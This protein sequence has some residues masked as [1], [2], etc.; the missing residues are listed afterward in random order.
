MTRN[1]GFEVSKG[2]LGQCW[3]VDCCDWLG[4]KEDDICGLD[5]NRISAREKMV[6]IYP[7]SIELVEMNDYFFNKTTSGH[8][9][10]RAEKVIYQI[11]QTMLQEK[12]KIFSAFNGV[13]LDI[14]KLSSG[15]KTALNI[16]YFPDKIVGIQECGDNALNV[17]YSYEQGNVYCE[18]PMISFQMSRV[19][20]VDQ[21]GKHI[22]D[23]YEVV[24]EW[25]SNVQ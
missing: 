9:D 15:C 8:I 1:T 12:Y 7:K 21:Y 25:W 5:E 2:S 17:I 11:D 19:A 3:L 10:E 18:Y 14:D 22:T 13:T 23:D 6:D 20:L 24:K 16:L 4:R